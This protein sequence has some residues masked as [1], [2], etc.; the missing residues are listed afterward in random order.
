MKNMFLTIVMIIGLF[1]IYL[2]Y[3]RADAGN[4]RS[5]YLLL[6]GSDSSTFNFLESHKE[7]MLA[8]RQ[9]IAA[10]PNITTNAFFSNVVR[11]NRPCKFLT[12]AKEWN[13]ASMSE[14][15]MLDSDQ[16]VLV[17]TNKN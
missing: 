5:I 1:I 11:M 8:D 7:E 4:L 15:E 6:N 10:W 14:S 13:L 3:F 12:L 16:K 2:M 17:Y 9:M